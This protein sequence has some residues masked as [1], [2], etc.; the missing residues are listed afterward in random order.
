MFGK[1][2][3]TVGDHNANLCLCTAGDV[4]IKTAGR[5][6]TIFKNGKLAVDDS[7]EIFVVDSEEDMK[8]TGIYVVN[9]TSDPENPSQ[10]VFL[11]VDGIKMLLAS[12]AEGYVSYTT[13]QELKPEQFIQALKNI[14]VYFQTVE[15]AKA[16]A[17]TEGLVYIL[18]DQK[19]YKIVNGELT[20]VIA[21]TGSGGTG[22]GTGGSGDGSE[23]EPEPIT[24][25]QI[26]GIFIDGENNV[27]SA[28]SGLVVQVDG[29]DYIWFKNNQVFIKRDLIISP[30][31]TFMVEG[32]EQGVS[33]MMVYSK[34][35]EIYMEVDNLLV[36]NSSTEYEPQLYSTY[37]GT[38]VKNQIKLAEW[39]TAP[40]DIVLTLKYQ[41]TFAVGDYILV[42]TAGGNQVTITT[43]S[44]DVGTTE[45]QEKT[46]Q[47]VQATLES[48]PSQDVSLKVT[49]SYSENEVE[50]TGTAD[51]LIP[52]QVLDEDTGSMIPNTY[53]ES[54]GIENTP[55]IEKIKSVEILSGDADIY[56]GS[57][58]GHTPPAAMIGTVTS[59]DPFTINLP[60]QDNSAESILRNMQHSP[61]YKIGSTTDAVH[62]LYH[63]GNSV[64]LQECT[65][66]SGALVRKTTTQIGDLST[67]QKP[68]PTGSTGPGDTFSGNG[69]Y[70][71]NFIG[72]NSKFYGGTFE[73]I[74]G[75]EYPVYGDS[76]EFP[77]TSFDDASYDK[78]I[79]CIGWVKE[80]IK[81]AIEDSKPATENPEPGP[82]P[83][84]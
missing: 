67:I 60:T 9:S 2:H 69:V 18:E 49:Y 51:I 43:K 42:Q 78:V 29:S 82:A 66:E 40:T 64:S 62:I 8:K 80:L 34:D 20:E 12:D 30:Q 22:E 45:G 50:R 63:S 13:S 44:I 6:V 83:G 31:N 54:A 27:I 68:Q 7:S 52:A 79:P 74:E 38:S 16:A 1:S 65:V 23:K 15:D 10:S 57:S 84:G 48:A 24:T 58:G 71:D 70:S 33:G 47:K 59:I 75:S 77:A 73:G 21:N 53:G 39:A 55:A 72:V 35:G 14:G 37:V 56:Y 11:Y 3:N 17:L 61:I 25:L 26:G 19:L 5:F 28:T 46:V 4:T 41:N 81:K 32:S 36:H 76:L